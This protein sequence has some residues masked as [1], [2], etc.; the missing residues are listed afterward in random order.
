MID[1]HCHI[2]PDV[3]DGAGSWDI[4]L[5]MCAMA[6]EDG[7]EH[8]VA[9]PHANSEYA[10]DRAY[11]QSLLEE[12]QRR[13]DSRLSLSLGCDFHFSYENIQEAL[14]DPHRFTIAGTNYLLVEFSNFS[15]PPTTSDQLGA[16][17]RE[18]LIPIVTHPERNPIL[19][20]TPDSVVE[21]VALGCLA[22]VTDPR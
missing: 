6:A 10:Y 15:I 20:R 3:D 8:I 12:L 4:A 2:L 18:G 11:L 19:Q 16:L 21:W 5:G 22:Q 7:I 1:I 9:T 17:I 13:A 14:K